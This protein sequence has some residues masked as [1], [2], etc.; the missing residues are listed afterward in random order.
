MTQPSL[1]LLQEFDV[2]AAAAV[3]GAAHLREPEWQAL[4]HAEA[5]PLLH[6]VYLILYSFIQKI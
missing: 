5:T 6:L 3:R 1:E 2:E 4:L